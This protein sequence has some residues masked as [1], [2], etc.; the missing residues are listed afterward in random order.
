MVDLEAI[1]EPDPADPNGLVSH[2]WVGTEFEAIRSSLDYDFHRAAET[3]GDVRGESS[4]HARPVG[5]QGVLRLA[6]LDEIAPF[7]PE[8]VGACRIAGPAF[9][10]HQDLTSSGPGLE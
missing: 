7:Q 4:V 6:N 1:D 5:A 10:I 3:S 2:A 8:V 9:Q